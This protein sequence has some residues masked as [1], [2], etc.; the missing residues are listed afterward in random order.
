MS[1]IYEAIMQTSS[2]HYD[3]NRTI[4]STIYEAIMPGGVSGLALAGPSRLTSCLV[5][6]CLFCVT[7]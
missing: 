5:E 2:P 4:M 1:T 3:I 6:S 7:V